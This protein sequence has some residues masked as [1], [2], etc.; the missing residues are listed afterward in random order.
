MATEKVAWKV[1]MGRSYRDGGQLDALLK[2]ATE[3]VEPSDRMIN[4][5][6]K[7][8]RLPF[9]LGTVLL[10]LT[11]IDT[12]MVVYNALRGRTDASLRVMYNSHFQLW[13]GPWA[14]GDCLWRNSYNVRSVRARG[15]F[16]QKTIRFLVKQLIQNW[17]CCDV[18]DKLTIVSLGSGSASQLLQGVADN[19]LNGS[20]VQVILVDRDSR[21]LKTGLRNAQRL[22]LESAVELQE[23]TIGKFLWQVRRGSVDLFEM[24]GLADYFKDGQIKRYFQRIFDALTPGGF[25]LGANISL[26]KE[27]DFAHGAACWPPMYYRTR[28]ELLKLLKE[29]GFEQIWTGSCGLYTVW[30][31]QKIP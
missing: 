13:R 15:R 21:A 24:V 3:G 6:N 12:L 27:K 23:T 9:R 30:V 26:Q 16:V 2:E 14:L 29:A 17:T 5:Y 25:F 19:G 10:L 31:A 1:Y 20:N 22:N 4:F 8:G 18:R 7:V 28:Q 11:G